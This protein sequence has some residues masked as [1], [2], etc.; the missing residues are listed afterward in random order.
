METQDKEMAHVLG[1]T[2]R[3][4]VVFITLF[5]MVLSLKLNELLFRECSIKYFQI[6]V[7]AGNKL[8][9]ANCDSSY[10]FSVCIPYLIR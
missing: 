1:G 4:F 2:E 6:T 7:E 8:Q 10:P 3:D 5:R 9:E